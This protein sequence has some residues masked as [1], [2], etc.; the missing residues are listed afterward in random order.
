MTTMTTNNYNY[1]ESAVFPVQSVPAINLPL[2][3]HLV[4]NVI[5]YKGFNH[6]I[7]LAIVVPSVPASPANLH[8]SER[9]P[10]H[11]Y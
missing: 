2:V 8:I 3:T 11:H 4:A 7:L 5:V 6:L 1:F 9:D 10:C